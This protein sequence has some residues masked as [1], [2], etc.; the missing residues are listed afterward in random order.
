MTDQEQTDFIVNWP[1]LFNGDIHLINNYNRTDK[2]LGKF[3]S[4]RGSICY[5]N[6]IPTAEA[7]F[8]FGSIFAEQYNNVVKIED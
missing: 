1:Y 7:I 6:Y 8:E 2:L 3:L 5:R 4:Y